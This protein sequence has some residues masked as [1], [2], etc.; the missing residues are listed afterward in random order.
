MMS[1]YSSLFFNIEWGN[2]G[3]METTFAVK[4]Q[5][6]VKIKLGKGDCLYTD[7]V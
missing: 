7:M 6:T 3:V 5:G 2:W 1:E 4:R